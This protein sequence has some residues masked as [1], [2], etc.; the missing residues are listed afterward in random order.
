MLNVIQCSIH[1]VGIDEQRTVNYGGHLVILLLFKRFECF[2]VTKEFHEKSTHAGKT[3]V[4]NKSTINFN[5][6]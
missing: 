5:H 3:H 1:S 2:F 4:Q 6:I